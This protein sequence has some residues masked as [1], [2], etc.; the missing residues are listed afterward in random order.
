MDRRGFR[1]DSG[2][3]RAEENQIRER[4][5]AFPFAAPVYNRARLPKRCDEEA[6]VKA[7]RAMFLKTLDRLAI[8]WLFNSGSVETN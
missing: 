5:R 2:D 3:R 8:C 4:A 1:V 7:T 6:V